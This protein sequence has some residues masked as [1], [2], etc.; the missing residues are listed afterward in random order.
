MS[1]VGLLRIRYWRDKTQKHYDRDV[2]GGDSDAV[3]NAI[4]WWKD[5][6]LLLTEVDELTEALNEAG[7]EHCGCLSLQPE[8]GWLP[9]YRRKASA[10]G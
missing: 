8:E 7:W 2:V 1:D 10:Q 6:D 3:A 4:G 5:V 9:E